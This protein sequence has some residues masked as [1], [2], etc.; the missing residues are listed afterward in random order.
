MICLSYFDKN[1]KAYNMDTCTYKKSGLFKIEIVD[2]NLSVEPVKET[3][4]E[5]LGD[6]ELYRIFNQWNKDHP[7]YE[8]VP[9]KGVNKSKLFVETVRQYCSDEPNY[10]DH[11]LS[12]INNSIRKMIKDAFK[13]F[14]RSDFLKQGFKEAWLSTSDIEAVFE[15]L[16]QVHPELYTVVSPIDWD[17][18][19]ATD[20]CVTQKL[21]NMDLDNLYKIKS[22]K[23][24]SVVFNLDKHTERGSHWV[25]VL[26]DI[27]SQA[28]IYMDSGGDT[29][30]KEVKEFYDY[31]SKQIEGL[32]FYE[33]LIEHQ[34]TTY[35]CGIYVILF[36]LALI[37]KVPPEVLSTGI[38]AF[39]DN[40][41]DLF[42]KIRQMLF[43]T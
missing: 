33:N 41:S 30:P 7:D 43:S 6:N 15:K 4:T 18:L 13:P 3:V 2:N 10:C 8:I 1:I 34:Q 39:K 25:C 40:E 28:F 11:S 24:V 21:C 20:M 31:C 29:A 12:Y 14:P 17:T 23:I 22:K 5:C 19:L 37:H 42:Y 9:S 26:I 32:R 35:E 36:T 38:G 16:E 27:Q